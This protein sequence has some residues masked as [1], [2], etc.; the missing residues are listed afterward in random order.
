MACEAQEIALTPI[1]LTP[2]G[3]LSY[4]FG[5]ASAER[6]TGALNENFGPGSGL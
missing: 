6:S 3:V 4:L 1:A 2:E 5:R